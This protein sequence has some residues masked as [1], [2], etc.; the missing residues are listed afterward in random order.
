M[1]DRHLVNGTNMVL[2]PTFY[3]L[4]GEDAEIGT[5]RLTI[6]GHTRLVKVPHNQLAIAG[7]RQDLIVEHW[8]AYQRR[9]TSR[10]NAYSR[11]PMLHQCLHYQ[12]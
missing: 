7:T 12:F 6:L 3:H 5:T 11:V 4:S 10:R 9:K 8:L 1:G 2:S